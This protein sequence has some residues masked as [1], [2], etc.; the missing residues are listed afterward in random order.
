M[1]G[2][3]TGRRVESLTFSLFFPL[4]LLALTPFYPYP[5]P[6]IDEVFSSLGTKW[7]LDSVVLLLV[8]FWE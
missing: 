8:L 3:F 6:T 7:K 1:G 2:I 5:D 4:A